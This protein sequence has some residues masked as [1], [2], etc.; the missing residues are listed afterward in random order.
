[1]ARASLSLICNDG[2]K[3]E[4]CKLPPAKPPPEV[5]YPT[6]TLVLPGGFKILVAYSPR[7]LAIPKPGFTIVEAENGV[8]VFQF[9]VV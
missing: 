8:G 7:N 3:R 2:H 1:M 4:V 6:L 9:R 5:P